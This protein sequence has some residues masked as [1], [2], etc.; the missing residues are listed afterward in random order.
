LALALKGE[1]SQP[2]TDQHP[3]SQLTSALSRISRRAPGTSVELSGRGDGATIVTPSA[4]VGIAVLTADI[5]A[6]GHVAQ[7]FPAS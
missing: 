5:A 3:E 4:H 6:G 7:P 2:G 1:P